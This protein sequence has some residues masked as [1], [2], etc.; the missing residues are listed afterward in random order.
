MKNEKITYLA[1]NKHC[2][3]LTWN[4][5]QDGGP[6]PSKAERKHMVVDEVDVSFLVFDWFR[7]FPEISCVPRAVGVVHFSNPIGSNIPQRNEFNPKVLQAT[8]SITLWEYFM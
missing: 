4:I 6:L 2:N 3:K 1:S 7:V 8:E 5:Q